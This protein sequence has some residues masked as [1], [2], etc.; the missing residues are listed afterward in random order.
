MKLAAESPLLCKNAPACSARVL[1]SRSRVQRSVGPPSDLVDWAPV[2]EFCLV[3]SQSSK[4]NMLA[5][6]SGQYAGPIH[7][8]KNISKASQTHLR[9]EPDFPHRGM[10]CFIWPSVLSLSLFEERRK[11]DF[12]ITLHT[13][14]QLIHVR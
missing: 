14:C 7:N 3:N 10:K 13:Y 11:H 1:T 2:S 4:I 5:H 9:L 6:V 8:T 12:Q